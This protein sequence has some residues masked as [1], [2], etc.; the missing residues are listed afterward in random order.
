MAV[1][2]SDLP[3]EVFNPEARPYIRRLNLQ[4]RDLFALEGTI[5]QP[6]AKST[7]D[8]SVRRSEGYQVHVS[9]I[10]P[11]VAS[12][13][14]GTSSTIGAPSLTWSTTSAAGSTN[15][16]V[17][18]NSTVKYPP[19]ISPNSKTSTLIL[20]DDGTDHILTSSLGAHIWFP[21]KVSVGNHEL[22]GLYDAFEVT[23]DWTI[24]DAGSGIR[25]IISDCYVTP[26]ED[27][28]GVLGSIGAPTWLQNTSFNYTGTVFSVNAVVNNSGTGTIS[29]ISG[30]RSALNTLNAS[31]D[32]TSWAGFRHVSPGS[33][34][35]TV[36]TGY[37]FYHEAH[38]SNVT[39]KWSFYAAADDAYFNNVVYVND[40]ISLGSAAS[41]PGDNILVVNQT[42]TDTSAHTP[43]S[44]NAALNP[45][46]SVSSNTT[47]VTGALSTTF[48]N[49]QNFTGIYTGVAY[50]IA[51]L[52][53]GTM[54]EGRGA[55][56]T[57]TSIGTITDWYGFIHTTPVLSAGGTNA[58]GFYHQGNDTDYTN[59]WAFYAAADNS[60]FQ[61]VLMDDNIKLKLGTGQ[62]GEIYFNA[63]D[64]IVDATAG[65]LVMLGNT[66]VDF[67]SAFGQYRF[68]QTDES[69]LAFS[70][71]M[72]ASN[73]ARVFQS[74][75]LPTNTYT[76]SD[77]A[78][79]YMLW[80][81]SP[82][83]GTI[84]RRMG[85][86]IDFRYNGSTAD[87]TAKDIFAA[88]MDCNIQSSS[89]IGNNSG[90]RVG[91]I[92]GV[93]DVTIGTGKT[94]VSLYGMAVDANSITLNGT[95]AVTNA[96]GYHWAGWPSGP[97]NAYAFYGVTDPSYFGSSSVTPTVTVAQESPGQ[98]IF[99]FTGDTGAGTTY[100]I[101]GFTN[102]G[103]IQGNIM[104]TIQGTTY[105]MPFY[106]DPS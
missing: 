10:V 97:A 31:C 20:T 37:G 50:S 63:T 91:S 69:T 71:D 51:H 64:L 92:L 86:D 22:L 12:V 42:F 4:L 45:S 39:A 62:D 8:L 6:L 55:T 102:P 27:V 98:P 89:T 3:E 43:V 100:T 47:I 60:Y 16:V 77:G 79:F 35:G 44:L 88:S 84:T 13:V 57:H 66:R 65:S 40:A 24:T 52:G 83:S 90:D 73:A 17:S 75:V 80:N 28:S 11:D 78:A 33:S 61:N 18:I 103:V 49:V 25:N 76:G 34:A 32:V 15:T 81:A 2:Y 46:A 56:V 23:H 58:Y 72:R 95:G 38:A 82:T 74:V 30:V 59:K 94:L 96:Y 104:V 5:K 1:R 21:Q 41:N 36:D 106:N 53:S 93:L 26:T 7:S 105:W 87:T 29:D 14:A 19:G 9:R 68:F 101:T 54:D 70:I 48:G 67:K 99:G 85:F